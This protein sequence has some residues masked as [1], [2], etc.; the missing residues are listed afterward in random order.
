[1]TFNQFV[2]YAK[3]AK[4]I[5]TD[6]YPEGAIYQCVD[7]IAAK[8]HLV[9]HVPYAAYGNAIDYCYKRDARL[10]KYYDYIE[11][12][13]PIRGDIVVLE[14]NIV[15]IIK[16]YGYGH[17]I[18][19]LDNAT[20]KSVKGLE[21]N[22]YNGNGSGEGGNA[23]RARNIPLRRIACILR[24]KKANRSVYAIVRAGEGLSQVAK[25][26][27]YKDFGRPSR[28]QAMA[29]LNGESDWRH[30]NAHLQPGQKIRIR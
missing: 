18:L 27:G 5:D 7:L 22:G 28:W 14:T 25:R 4:R 26:Y 6:G 8:M 17:M 20:T 12:K 19:A 2:T 15:P 24:P 9:E 29:V 30:F 13:S 1:M 10:A 21:Q 11:D 3:E 16:G 23:I